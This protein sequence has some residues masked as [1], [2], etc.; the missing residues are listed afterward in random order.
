MTLKTYTNLRV[1]SEPASSSQTQPKHPTLG[2]LLSY[3]STREQL[4]VNNR[5]FSA[6]LAKFHASLIPVSR[7]LCPTMVVIGVVESIERLSGFDDC[8]DTYQWLY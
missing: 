3:C 2:M 8:S 4:V 5:P 6:I 7:V 1:W